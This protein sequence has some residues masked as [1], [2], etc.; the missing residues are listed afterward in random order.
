MRKLA[1]LSLVLV[2]FVSIFS[3]GAAV[4][5]DNW[6][7][8]PNSSFPV[9]ED[10]R[11]LTVECGVNGTSATIQGCDN[12]TSTE[13]VCDTSR[14]FTENVRDEGIVQAFMELNTNVLILLVVALLAVLGAIYRYR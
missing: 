10:G 4:Q 6:Q 3:V 8:P 7:C 2:Y 14:T 13:G 5:S 9:I 11:V 12:L 1:V